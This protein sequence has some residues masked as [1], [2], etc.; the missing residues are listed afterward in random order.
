M[1]AKEDSSLGFAFIAGRKGDI[2]PVSFSCRASFNTVDQ[3][4][5]AEC[6]KAES[7]IFFQA[8]T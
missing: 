3:D 4:K 8:A 1:A 7:G 2:K 5:T 6:Q